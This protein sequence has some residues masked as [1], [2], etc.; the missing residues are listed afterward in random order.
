MTPYKFSI[1][2]TLKPNEAQ[3]VSSDDVRGRI[4]W[5]PSDE[6]KVFGGVINANLIKLAHMDDSFVHGLNME[7]LA[8]DILRKYKKVKNPVLLSWDGS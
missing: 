5:N 2:P 6:I 8:D 3:Y 4:V 7:S 1:T